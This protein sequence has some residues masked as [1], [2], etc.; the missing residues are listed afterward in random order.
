MEFDSMRFFIFLFLFIILVSPSVFSET[1]QENL[2][3]ILDGKIEKSFEILTP[4]GAGKKTIDEAKIQLQKEAKKVD[5]DGIVQVVC[6]PGGI[7]REGLSWSHQQPYCRGK[8]IRFL[9]SEK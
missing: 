3:A 8:A 1:A 5:A 2:P 9:K 6:E 7:R 4:V